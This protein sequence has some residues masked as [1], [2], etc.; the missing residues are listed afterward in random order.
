MTM[1]IAFLAACAGTLALAAT[2]GAFAQSSNKRIPGT[3]IGAFEGR[4]VRDGLPDRKKGRT[5]L[6]GDASLGRTTGRQVPR[7]RKISD[8]E[9]RRP[10]LRQPNK[11]GSSE[12]LTDGMMILR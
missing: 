5:F 2:A 1:R 3:D 4:K 10:I 8:N 11:R 12:P 9:N 6:D 7:G